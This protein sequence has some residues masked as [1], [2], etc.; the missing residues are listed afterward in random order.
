MTWP[1]LEFEGPFGSWGEVTVDY[2]E[3][4][5]RIGVLLG[6]TGEVLMVVFEERHPFGFQPR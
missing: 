5:E 1:G 6:P 2:P 3:E 4:P